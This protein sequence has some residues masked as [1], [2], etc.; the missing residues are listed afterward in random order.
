MLGLDFEFG[1]TEYRH[2]NVM[3]LLH[4]NKVKPFLSYIIESPRIF[5]GLC[6]YSPQAPVVCHITSLHIFS[7]AAD[8]SVLG[9][10]GDHEWRA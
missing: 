1:L 2:V 5:H 3:C 8:I 7:P 6:V 10:R 9:G 4:L